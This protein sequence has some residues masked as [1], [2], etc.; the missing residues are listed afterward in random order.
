M[1]PVTIVVYETVTLGL[2]VARGRAVWMRT[3][4][5]P[6]LPAGRVVVWVPIKVPGTPVMRV[7]YEIPLVIVG[8]ATEL[9][10][11]VRGT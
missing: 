9:L 1:M 7:M 2:D 4:A 11:S 5:D 3:V 8:V 6:S 10:V